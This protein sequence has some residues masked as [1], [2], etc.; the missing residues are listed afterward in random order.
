MT[1]DAAQFVSMDPRT[2]QLDSA[3]ALPA[4][5]VTLRTSTEC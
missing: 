2:I 5:T 1:S 4:L 3:S